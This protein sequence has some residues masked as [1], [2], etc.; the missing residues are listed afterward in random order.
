MKKIYL[1]DERLSRSFNSNLELVIECKE[2]YNNDKRE[3]H[4]IYTINDMYHAA[5]F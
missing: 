1:N 2:N 4:W 3:T 5:R